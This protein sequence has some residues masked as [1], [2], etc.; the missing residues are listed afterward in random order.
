MSEVYLLQVVKGGCDIRA[1]ISESKKKKKN[2]EVE[3][4]RNRTL[5]SV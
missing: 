5:K 1:E 4:S 3:E 2:I